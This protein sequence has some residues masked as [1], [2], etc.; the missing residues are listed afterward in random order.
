MAIA[1]L[2]YEVCAA[3][4]QINVLVPICQ[5]IQ[6]SVVGIKF[7]L[8]KLRQLQGTASHKV[9]P[10]SSSRKVKQTMSYN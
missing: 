10:S 8:G 9:S 6:S 5:D 3:T 7:K 4:L 1:L 2:C